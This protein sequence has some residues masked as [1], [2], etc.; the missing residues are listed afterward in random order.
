MAVQMHVSHS[1]IMRGVGVIA[2]VTYD[3]ANSSLST[4]GTTRGP[5]ASV[6]SRHFIKSITCSPRPGHGDYGGPC[7]GDNAKYV[8]NCGY[9]AAGQLLQH[10][11]GRLNPRYSNVANGSVLA[12]DQ[13]E[14]VEGGN[15]KSIGL[16]DTGYVYVPISCQVATPCRVHIVFH[17]CKQYAEK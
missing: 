10:I 16:A 2:G 7:L 17:G 1:S 15:P 14:F 8:N 5:R 13:R 3:C 4:L 6:P 11:Y 12:F 9:D